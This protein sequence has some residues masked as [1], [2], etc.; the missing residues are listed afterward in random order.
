MFPDGDTKLA[1]STTAGGA[2]EGAVD[3]TGGAAPS[4]A[5]VAV[6]AVV[7]GGAGLSGVPARAIRTRAS[8]T[9]PPSPARPRATAI[10][11]SKGGMIGAWSKHSEHPRRARIAAARDAG[12]RRRLRGAPGPGRQPV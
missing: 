5:V 7:G 3:G 8:A 1:V 9:A 6:G 2:R 10:S 4:A 11:P 12:R